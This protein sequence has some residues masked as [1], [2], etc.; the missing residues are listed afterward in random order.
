MTDAG[1]S[2]LKG[3]INLRSLNVAYTE[4]TKAAISE[5]RQARPNCE[6]IR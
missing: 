4:T 2:E 5:L 6:I 1:L 3:C